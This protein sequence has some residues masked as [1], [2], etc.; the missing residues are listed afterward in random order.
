MYPR[1]RELREDADMSQKQVAS[2]LHCTQQNYSCYERGLRD[3]PTQALI[4]LA[5]IHKT[6]TDYLL[7]RTDDRRPYP[8]K[9]P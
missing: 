8:K 2:V 3:I 9:K 7:G 4:Q 6:S 5:D 1:I